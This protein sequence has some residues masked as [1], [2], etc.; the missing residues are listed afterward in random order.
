[1]AKKEKKTVKENKHFFKEFKA[2]IKK[3][4]WP[5]SKQLVNTTVAIITMVIVVSIIVFGLDL[6]FDAMNK[7]GLTK[8]QETV[9]NIGNDKDDSSATEDATDSEGDSIESTDKASTVEEN[10]EESTDE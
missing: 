4:I 10:T 1:M 8:L 9:Q 3:V 6:A 5:T 7:Y 2:E